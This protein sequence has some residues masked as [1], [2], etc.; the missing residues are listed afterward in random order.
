LLYLFSSSVSFFPLGFL[1]G[2]VTPF[3][4]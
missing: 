1:F 3:A 2:K 4:P